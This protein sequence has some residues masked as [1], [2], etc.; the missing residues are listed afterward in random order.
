M[1]EFQAVARQACYES[2]FVASAILTR[3]IL[4]FETPFVSR[5]NFL[6]TLA[7]RGRSHDGGATLR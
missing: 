4:K 7:A 6:P 2:D 5:T 1:F 3:E